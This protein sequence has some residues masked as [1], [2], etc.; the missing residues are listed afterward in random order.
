ML[1]TRRNRNAEAKSL[2]EAATEDS[3]SYADAYLNWGLILAAEG[4]YAGA[5]NRLRKALELAPGLQK[6][7]VALDAIQKEL[8]K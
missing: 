1:C 6:A 2:F 3:P 4:D 7:S 8:S 5:R